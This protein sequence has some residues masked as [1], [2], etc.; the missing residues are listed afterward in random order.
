LGPLF[1]PRHREYKLKKAW[2][3][4]TL[5]DCRQPGGGTQAVAAADETRMKNS[6]RLPPGVDVVE[7]DFA[8]GICVPVHAKVALSMMPPEMLPSFKSMCQ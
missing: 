7:H 5:F 4:G 6:R 3:G 1:Y 8:E 2:F